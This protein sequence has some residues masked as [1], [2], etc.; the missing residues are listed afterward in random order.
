MNGR[1]TA[2]ALLKALRERGLLASDSPQGALRFGLPLQALRFVVP[3]LG[4]EADADGGHGP[5]GSHEAAS[6]R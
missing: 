1:G 2:G 4:P 3:A 5:A 6:P